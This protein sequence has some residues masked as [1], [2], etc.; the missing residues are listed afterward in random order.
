MCLELFFGQD[1]PDCCK[2]LFCLFDFGHGTSHIILLLHG[3]VETV[4]WKLA[5]TCGNCIVET[6]LYV[7]NL[8]KLSCTRTTLTMC[9]FI[10]RRMKKDESRGMEMPR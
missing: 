5:C 7:C 9:L 4:L 2:N 10:F 8:W 6:G 1:H 3:I